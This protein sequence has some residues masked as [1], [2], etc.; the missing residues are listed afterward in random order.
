ME[1]TA[2]RLGREITN[3]MERPASSTLVVSDTAAPA[4]GASTGGDEDGDE[5][6]NED[7]DEASI[8]TGR[9]SLTPSAV[10]DKISI[11]DLPVERLTTQSGFDITAAWHQ[12][13]ELSLDKANR[14]NLY[15]ASELQKLMSLSHIMLLSSDG[16]DKDMINIFGADVLEDFYLELRDKYLI[17]AIKFDPDMFNEVK[18][19]VELLKDGDKTMTRTKAHMSLASMLENAGSRNA[20]ILHIIFNCISKLPKTEK[21]Y[22]IAETELIT[23]YLDPI[24]SPMFHD[25][26]SNRLFRWLNQK[27]SMYEAETNTRPDGGM[28]LVEQLQDVYALGFVEVKAS[29]SAKKYVMTHMDTLRLSMFCKTA[30]DNNIKCAM[31]VQ[32]V[33]TH[34][35]FF[36]CTIEA[37]ALY[38]FLKIGR[39]DVPTSFESLPILLSQLD[40]CARIMNAYDTFC[41]KR[42]D[43]DPACPLTRPS[44]TQSQLSDVLH[45]LNRNA[46]PSLILAPTI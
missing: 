16:Y 42:N 34:V 23:N 30:L 37:E 29:C 7:E 32:A 2:G 14:H 18:N 31:A 10:P 6:M 24:L 27:S 15:V 1:A 39:L 38:P 45:E 41:T 19:I 8:A 33:G 28:S 40:T 17:K 36:L 46:T 11:G 22:V 3:R 26:D 35:T 43:K 9:S 13:K 5:N 44:L 4:S 21:S 12:Y 25:P 20:R